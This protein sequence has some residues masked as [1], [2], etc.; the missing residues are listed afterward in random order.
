[1]HPA[2]RTRSLRYPYPRTR[3]PQLREAYSDAGG[4]VYTGD[5]VLRVWG[6]CVATFA[7]FIW[8]R[9][10]SAQL[11]PRSAFIFVCA[12]KATLPGT[13]RGWWVCPA[14]RDS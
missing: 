11:L 10:L 6:T 1:M 9:R 2:T 4:Y 7:R 14:V 5:G 12:G 3:Q 8:Q 13:R